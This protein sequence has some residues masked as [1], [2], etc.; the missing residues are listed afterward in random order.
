MIALYIIIGLVALIAVLGS[1]APKALKVERS[2]TIERPAPEIFDYVKQ[3]ENMKE[4]GP[5]YKKDPNANYTSSGMDGSIG[6]VSKWA[7]NKE[8][9]E[10]EQE[11]T[12]LFENERVET[13]LRFIK[14]WKS[15]SQAFINLEDH[16]NGTTTVSWGFTGNNPFPMNI[17]S[18]FL[19]MDKML[20]KDF[21]SG[22]DNLK[23]I[24]EGELV[25]S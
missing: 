20:G 10:G 18:L 2:V 7:G 6:Y 1:I 19:N 14:P 11:I 23:G 22:L 5:W 4:W 17:M 13:E 21:E 8:V 9:G 16:Q 3:L 24:L 25:A 12:G 15:Q